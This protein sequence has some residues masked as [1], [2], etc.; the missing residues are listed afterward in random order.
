[1]EYSFNNFV[2]EQRLRALD[3]EHGVLVEFWSFIPR[4]LQS[5]SLFCGMNTGP[6]KVTICTEGCADKIRLQGRSLSGHQSNVLLRGLVA[7]GLDQDLG[8]SWS[9]C[10]RRR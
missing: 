9:C 1:M 2:W 10:R 8:R 5:G 3:N 7:Y 4:C 6:F